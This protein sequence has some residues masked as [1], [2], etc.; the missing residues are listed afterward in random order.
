MKQALVFFGISFV[1]GL[2]LMS[3]AAA[4]SFWTYY[5]QTP[6]INAIDV[7]AQCMADLN[8]ET[9][10]LSRIHTPLGECLEICDD[11]SGPGD[12]RDK[13]GLTHAC[14]MGVTRYYLENAE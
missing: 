2:I 4:Y 1:S 12:Y 6:E 9:V 8:A 3:L 13:K 7:G 14:K 10:E 5:P 11:L